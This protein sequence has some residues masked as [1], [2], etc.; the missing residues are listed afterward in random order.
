MMSDIL[1]VDADRNGATSGG[2]IYLLDR[3]A[4][5]HQKTFGSQ[6]QHI[7]MHPIDNTAPDRP[8]NAPHRQYSSGSSGK[9]TP[10]KI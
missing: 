7:Q 5:C 8:A 4:N 1:V 6:A 9:L 3:N 10:S 2:Y